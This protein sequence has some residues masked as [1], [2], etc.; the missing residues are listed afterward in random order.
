MYSFE[1]VFLLT[2]L[3]TRKLDF[4][5]EYRNKIKM[6]SETA[7]AIE[8]QWLFDLLS[9]SSHIWKRC[10]QKIYK[11]FSAKYYDDNRRYLLDRSCYRMIREEVGVWLKSSSSVQITGMAG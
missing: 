1:V 10:F 9:I 3:N 4:Y 5:M 7:K 11:Y 2:Y 8:Y 6:K